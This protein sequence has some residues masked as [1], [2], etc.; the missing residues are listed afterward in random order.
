MKQ[1]LVMNDALTTTKD[2]GVSITAKKGGGVSLKPEE[3][4]LD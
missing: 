2:G 4:P 3:C 1:L